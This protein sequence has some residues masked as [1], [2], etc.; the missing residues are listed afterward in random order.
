MLGR[1]PNGDVFYAHPVL[2]PAR[3]GPPSLPPAPP[4]DIDDALH[5]EHP[6][7]I[8]TC[9]VAFRLTCLINLTMHITLAAV[10]PLAAISVLASLLGL[11]AAS[12]RDT[13]LVA[14]YAALAAV[15]AAVFT[16]VT[17]SSHGHHPVRAFML[18]FA[19]GK[20]A[21]A[22]IA[23]RLALLMHAAQDSDG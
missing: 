3:P 8:E 9:I 6:A 2:A 5:A 15:L 13:R 11:L 18:P 7:Q 12:L 21:G 16:A 22:A 14:T 20:L 19:L 17:V 23:C 4:P 1:N 10:L